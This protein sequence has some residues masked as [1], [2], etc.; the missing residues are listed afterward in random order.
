MTASGLPTAIQIVGRRFDD[1]T[2]LRIAKALE[3]AR[4]WA[5]GLAELGRRYAG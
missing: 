3:A 1:P 5:D 4:P 2:V